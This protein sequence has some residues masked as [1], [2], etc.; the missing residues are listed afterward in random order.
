MDNEILIPQE[1][2]Y[3]SEDGFKPIKLIINSKETNI[4]SDIS[5]YYLHECLRKEYQ[6]YGASY[7][8]QEV[9]NESLNNPETVYFYNDDEEPEETNPTLQ[10]NSKR[11][12][13]ED[14]QDIEPRGENP[15]TLYF[16]NEEESE[17]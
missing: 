17:P 9:I 2:P 4:S 16:V 10:V 11:E 5:T 13:I 1:S 6:E 14:E 15:T 12:I 3:P 8:E 7:N